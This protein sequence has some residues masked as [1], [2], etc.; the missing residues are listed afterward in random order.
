MNASSKRVNK[1]YSR[2]VQ[3][4]YYQSK[5]SVSNK[6]RA[7]AERA[8]NL[9]LPGVETRE[10]HAQEKKRTT[11]QDDFS[12]FI[13]IMESDKK[14]KTRC[15]QSPHNTNSPQHPPQKKTAFPRQNLPVA[16]CSQ[17]GTEKLDN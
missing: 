7:Q 13:I 1:K 14:A 10:N 11:K 15:R 4:K 17:S 8:Q 6:F 16:L 5:N 9:N 12:I 2:A 3:R